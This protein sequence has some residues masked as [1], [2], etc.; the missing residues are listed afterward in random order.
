MAIVDVYDAAVSRN[1][2]RPSM[3]HDEAVDL[4]VRGS[5]THFDPAVVNAFVAVARVLRNVSE[6]ALATEHR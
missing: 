3:T 1:L 2:Y 4:I 6:E 5:G